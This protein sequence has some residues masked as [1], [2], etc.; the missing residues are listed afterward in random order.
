MS[1]AHRGALLKRTGLPLFSVMLRARI[2]LWPSACQHNCTNT[3]MQWCMWGKHTVHTRSF[4][5][6]WLLEGGLITLNVPHNPAAGAGRGVFMQGGWIRLPKVLHYEL[7]WC[8]SSLSVLTTDVDHYHMNDVGHN[9]RQS[10]NTFSYPIVI[11]SNFKKKTTW[12][13]FLKLREQPQTDWGNMNQNI[14]T[15]FSTWPSFTVCLQASICH[16]S[17]YYICILSF[18]SVNF[19]I[20]CYVRPEGL[21]FCKGQKQWD[22]PFKFRIHP[23]FMTSMYS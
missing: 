5:P 20:S 1:V 18:L 15:S 17:E 3:L 16:G 14:A 2:S 11:I 21:F 19:P 23:V 22:I 7:Y 8:L 13:Y 10:D 6:Y 9:K 4:P 12:K